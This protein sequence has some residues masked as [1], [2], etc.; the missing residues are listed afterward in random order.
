M[1][2]PDIATAVHGDAP[3]SSHGRQSP[4][5]SYPC[6]DG[7]I[8]QPATELND[9]GAAC[10]PNDVNQGSAPHQREAMSTI[11]KN[12]IDDHD[13]DFQL[14]GASSD[15]TGDASTVFQGS[16]KPMP[17][18]RNPTPPERGPSPSS[19][20]RVSSLEKL[21]PVDSL[22]TIVSFREDVDRRLNGMQKQQV[23]FQRSFA[24]SAR[25][26]FCQH[27]CSNVPC[28]LLLKLLRNF[29]IREKK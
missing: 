13:D 18:F 27:T 6:S 8:G 23:C 10:V 5:H 25:T 2:P 20:L 16:L 1:S 15:V 29:H 21:P 14:P 3:L 11:S 4:L 9:K 7:E 17:R 12:P 22:Q 28:I 19:N 26:H 24:V